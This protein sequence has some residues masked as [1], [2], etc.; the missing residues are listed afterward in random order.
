VAYDGNLGL[1]QIGHNA[2]VK[3]LDC[4]VSRPVFGTDIEVEFV[5]KVFIV[6]IDAA[7]EIHI[8]VIC[9]PVADSRRIIRGRKAD[10]PTGL[11]IENIPGIKV[12]GIVICRDIPAQGL[13]ARVVKGGSLNSKVSGNADIFTRFDDGDF[14]FGFIESYLFGDNRL[15]ARKIDRGYN[16]FILAV[17]KAVGIEVEMPVRVVRILIETVGVVINITVFGRNTAF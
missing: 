11:G 5:L 2:D 9:V 10:A 3:G 12:V 17:I 8:R 6:R 13:N 15:P 4:D 16:D 7:L 1:V 14:R